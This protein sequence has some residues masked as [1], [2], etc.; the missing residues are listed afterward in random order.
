[1]SRSS[2]LV[3]QAVLL[4]LIS[5]IGY[6]AALETTADTGFNPPP[7]EGSAK[8][9][10]AAI[11]AASKCRNMHVALW[12][13]DAAEKQPDK[14]VREHATRMLIRRQMWVCLELNDDAVSRI[15]RLVVSHDDLVV[16]LWLFKV[17][18]PM[19]T[20]KKLAV[21]KKLALEDKDSHIRQ[22]AV[23]CLA[24]PEPLADR[25]AIREVLIKTDDTRVRV[26][27]VTKLCELFDQRLPEV[28]TSHFKEYWE[29]WD[30]RDDH[31]TIISA[32]WMSD[33]QKAH[34]M[35]AKKVLNT[36][37]DETLRLNALMLLYSGAV[38]SGKTVTARSACRTL[39]K[40]KS[41][42]LRKRAWEYLAIVG[43]PRENNSIAKACAQE[44][45]P[46]IR[47][48]ALFTLAALG[49]RKAAD[50]ALIEL[51]ADPLP[52]GGQLFDLLYALA[53]LR[54]KRCLQYTHLVAKE[55]EHGE[56]YPLGILGTRECIPHLVKLLSTQNRWGAGSAAR[57]I[58]RIGGDPA[59]KA[60]LENEKQYAGPKLPYALALCE[61]GA[62]NTWERIEKALQAKELWGHILPAPHRTKFA[63]IY[64]PRLD[65]EYTLLKTGHVEG[66]ILLVEVLNRCFPALVGDVFKPE[67]REVKDYS[68]SHL[69]RY[70]DSNLTYN[71][72]APY[73]ERVKAARKLKEWWSANRYGLAWDR[74]ISKFVVVKNQTTEKQKKLSAIS[75]EEV[76]A[77]EK[78]IK[79]LLDQIQKSWK[80]KY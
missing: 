46:K 43:D 74:D 24:A 80:P 53:L 59:K 62:E 22:A 30:S 78:A 3:R 68:L 15:L 17:L 66:L 45:D 52:S 38:I 23:S 28:I 73:E 7:L 19:N 71:S 20:R 16:R 18:E 25:D 64:A 76:D 27:C 51:Q 4:L 56:V 1:M 31:M 39:A 70:F 75:R 14:K 42:K 50:L 37:L 44:K 48:Q 63:G 26:R 5:V 32:L 65:S 21:A 11:D 34:K 69:F 79:G 41:A 40:A 33:D 13:L 29:K 77:K 49:Y 35:L 8:E 57:A 47:A 36:D 61:A 2:I 67:F 55:I 10:I 6:V 12:L 58:G 9:R 72:I 60:L 54:D